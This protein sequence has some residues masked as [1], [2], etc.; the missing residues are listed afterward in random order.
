M[1]PKLLLRFFLPL[2]LKQYAI[3]AE[4]VESKYRLFPHKIGRQ[5]VDTE[6]SEGSSI[7]HGNDMPEISS[8][9]N[10][11]SPSVDEG[12]ETD[13]NLD[14][15]IV[16]VTASADETQFKPQLAPPAPLEPKSAPAAPV[17]DQ[18]ATATAENSNVSV[19]WDAV[20]AIYDAHY[21]SSPSKSGKSEA[22]N[23]RLDRSKSGKELT[24]NSGIS[25]PAKSSKRV[26]K[27]GK[28]NES[29][30][31][32][33]SE[34]VWTDIVNI[35][36][37]YMNGDSQLN[38]NGPASISKSGKNAHTSNLFQS[39]THGG[40]KASKDSKS[41]SGKNASIAIPIQSISSETATT[42]TSTATTTTTTTT[43]ATTTTTTVS[44][45]TSATT[46]ETTSTS[47]TATTTTESTSTVLP[48]T[49]STTVPEPTT[50]DIATTSTST[51]TTATTTTESTSTALP[52]TT[53]TTVSEP[54]TTDIATTSTATTTAVPQTTSASATTS[55]TTPFVGP[56]NRI[57]PVDCD[58]C[59]P[60]IDID[61]DQAIM[62][63]KNEQVQFLSFNE[64]SRRLEPTTILS[65][66]MEFEP[67]AV[68]ISGNIAAIGHPGD[69][70]EVLLFEQESP[71]IWI[72][73]GTINDPGNEGSYFGSDVAVDGDVIVVGASMIGDDVGTGA[74]YIYRLNADENGQSTWDLEATLVADDAAD[75]P[76][77]EFGNVVSVK[78]NIIVVGDENHGN[79]NSGAA[80]VY[81]YDPD[82]TSWLQVGSPITNDECELGYFGTAVAIMENGN[83]L[84]SCHRD[85]DRRGA[86]FYYTRSTESDEYVLQQKIV[87]A[88][89]KSDDEFGGLYKTIAVDGNTMAIGTGSRERVYIFHL[90]DDDV[91]NEASYLDEP[92]GFN[93]VQFGSNLAMSG[94]K[95][96]IR[97]SGNAYFYELED[98]GGSGNLFE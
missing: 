72:N 45:S 19:D 70:G 5:N 42:T 68:S 17:I 80:Y 97:S 15:G 3:G 73:L 83:L 82:I 92:A 86:V 39:P 91:W 21:V 44:E 98:D 34:A 53:S 55:T 8:S 65:D 59:F 75:S 26:G 47:T 6:S 77:E 48:Q 29:S 1:F 30:T 31:N 33:Q 76:Y 87:A 13:I 58:N 95:L 84:I 2:L 24:P 10:N 14:A 85:N 36:N 25:S 66:M 71:G 50:T 94:N 81:Q 37:T 64:T 89:G 20:A 18:S 57:F 79:L 12:V 93:V 38:S 88:D 28:H 11:E 60:M 41:K 56:E 49:T 27:G 7:S 74:V 96:L 40:G 43:A 61:G 78:G 63:I 90:Q 16:A 67:T 32:E 62:F 9:A 52:Q 23:P 46:Q 35:A 4:Y 22:F 51:A 69:V 54:T